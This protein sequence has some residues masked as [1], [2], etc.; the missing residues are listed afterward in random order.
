M[1]IF[2]GLQIVD[3]DLLL[4]IAPNYLHEAVAKWWK[5][6]HEISGSTGMTWE[7]FG[8]PFLNEFFPTILRERKWV[9]FKKLVQRTLMV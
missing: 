9:D 8:Q 6:Q 3:D 5:V 4:A 2:E 7:A 1:R